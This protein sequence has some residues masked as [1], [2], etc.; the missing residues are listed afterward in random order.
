MKTKTPAEMVLIRKACKITGDALK[1]AKTL[2]RPGVS[3]LELDDKISDF[4]LKQGATLSFKGYNG[5]PAG[6]CAS[7]NEVVVHGIP[8]NYVLKQGDILSIDLGACYKGYHGDAARTFAVGEISKENQQLIK[9]TEECFFK[10]IENLRSGMRVGEF[11]YAVL[12]HAESFG[13][14][15]VRELVGHGIGA[16]MHE[17]PSIPNY[18][19]ITDGPIIKNNVC[20]AIE[21]MITAGKKEIYILSDGWTIV[22]RDKKPAAHYENTVFVTENG[23]EI[24]TD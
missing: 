4:I 8:N 14:G 24:L 11:G 16:N 21:P 5:Y 13:Y 3:L 20:L 7:V 23:V 18:G 12:Q 9:V 10:A 17:E 6:I 1:Y 19:K 15:V 22:T 2:V